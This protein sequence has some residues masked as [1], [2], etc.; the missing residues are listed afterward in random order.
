MVVGTPGRTLDHLR[1]GNLDLNAVRFLVLDEADEMLDKGFAHD[2]EA[3]LDRTPR[4]RQTTLFSATMP[5][6]VE[7]TAKKH[8]RVPEKVEIDGHV[9]APPTVE[10]LVYT[11]QKSEKIQALQ[12][13]LDEQEGSIIVF[14]RTKHGVRKLARQ[15]DS[16]GYRVGALQGNLKQNARERV[17]AD[18][19]SGAAPVLVATNVAARGLDVEGVDQVVNYDLPDSQQLFTHRVGRTGRMGRSGEAIT[20]VTPDE[21]RKWR[22]IE[23]GLSCRI[24]RESWQAARGADAARTG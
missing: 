16:L 6:W 20:F 3:I 2:V 5:K 24:T 22:E 23:R 11:I 8:L 7:N 12:T 9:Q 18:F 1:Q 13:L 19:R 21:G 4:E 14:G 17:L 10:H 15:L